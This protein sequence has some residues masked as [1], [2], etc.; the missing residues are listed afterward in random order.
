MSYDVAV[1]VGEVPADDEAAGAVFADLAEEFLEGAELEPAAELAAFTEAVNVVRPGSPDESW[2]VTVSGPIAYFTLAYGEI[3]DA[4]GPIEQLADAN[5]LVCFNPQTGR[6]HNMAPRRGIT[7]AHGAVAV[8]AHWMA[9]LGQEL[10][11]PNGFVTLQDG[12][13]DHYIQAMNADGT[14][15][16][17]YRDGSPEQHFQTT[18]RNHLEIADAIQQW[19][20]GE[21]EFVSQHAWERLR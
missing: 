16:L 20:A 11:D 15:L 5:G 1:W 2:Q 3:D 8:P 7:T 14:L 19:L 12:Q 13:A 4:V 9:F 17:E 10:R 18:V 21:R 6:V